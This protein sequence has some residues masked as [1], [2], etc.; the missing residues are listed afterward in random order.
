[1]REREREKNHRTAFIVGLIRQQISRVIS[2]GMMAD[3]NACPSVCGR[4]FPTT[5]KLRAVGNI[6][7]VSFY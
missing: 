1:M 5:A 3:P 2:L 7:F 6:I 4:F